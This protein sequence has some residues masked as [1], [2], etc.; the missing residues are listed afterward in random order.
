MENSNSIL[1]LSCSE[2]HRHTHQYQHL[3]YSIIVHHPQSTLAT[4]HLCDLFCL[5]IPKNVP[6]N[7]MVAFLHDLWC[8]FDNNGSWILAGDSDT[9]KKTLT[10]LAALIYLYNLFYLRTLIIYLVTNVLI[11]IQS[12]ATTFSLNLR[13]NISQ[14]S[15]RLSS[16]TAKDLISVI[17]RTIAEPARWTSASFTHINDNLQDKPLFLKAI[18][19]FL[20]GISFLFSAV[21]TSLAYCRH[22]VYLLAYSRLLMLSFIRLSGARKSCGIAGRILK[23]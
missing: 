7:K 21:S 6:I 16:L 3:Q 20:V 1:K 13:R 5:D 8:F 23:I 15:R 4:R 19:L 2:Q 11:R 9:L 12:A 18:F 10:I 22:Q 17:V 14:I